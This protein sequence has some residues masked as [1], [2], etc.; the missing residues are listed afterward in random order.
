[1]PLFL[2]RLLL[3]VS[4]FIVLLH[5]TVPHRHRTDLD[6]LSYG[7]GAASLCVD[8]PSDSGDLLS[9]A[10]SFNP[11]PGHFESIALADTDDWQPALYA[12][13]GTLV[14][15]LS[16]A[17]FA[18]APYSPGILPAAATPAGRDYPLDG[19]YCGCAGYT[20]AP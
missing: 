14:A 1:M 11:A 17:R 19:E 9:W 18:L 13:P 5:N 8:A 20:R 3:Y 16:S 4:A 10:L 12:L 15:E 7:S 6:T 2:R